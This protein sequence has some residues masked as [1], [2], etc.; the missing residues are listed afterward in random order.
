MRASRAFRRCAAGSV[1]AAAL[2]GAAAQAQTPGSYPA[3]NLLPA[4]YRLIPGA[5]FAVE[6]GVVDLPRFTHP[7]SNIR[8]QGLNL[9]LVGR[10]PLFGGLGFYGRL[11]STYGYAEGTPGAAMAGPDN[12]S[13]LAYGAGVSMDFTRRLSATL[14]WESHDFKFTGGQRATSLGLQYRY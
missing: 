12:G 5:R 2:L 11:G 13:T 7:G 6:M 10:A 14:G 9:S 1:A 3:M 8:A 4:D